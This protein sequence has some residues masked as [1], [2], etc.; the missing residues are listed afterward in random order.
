MGHDACF[1]TKAAL[2]RTHSKTLRAHRKLTKVRQVLECV[3][4]SA[5]FRL[6]PTPVSRKLSAIFRFLPS[7]CNRM[8]NFVSHP[9]GGLHRFQPSAF[10]IKMSKN[11]PLLVAPY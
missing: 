5:A 6:P 8:K 9:K 3:R 1:R 2:A 7:K 11:N 10:P 4:A